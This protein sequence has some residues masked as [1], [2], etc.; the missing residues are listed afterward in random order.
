MTAVIEYNAVS[1][2]A[3]LDVTGV[4]GELELFGAV[5]SENV[6]LAAVVTSGDVLVLNLLPNEVSLV[7]KSG[8]VPAPVV[9]LVAAVRVISSVVES[10]DDNISDVAVVTVASD[11]VAPDVS[12]AA[13]LVASRSV[14]SG[15]TSVTSVECIRVAF[16][17]VEPSIEPSVNI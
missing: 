17:V 3:S 5:P 4:S 11:D 8:P 2:L 12:A 16:A 9:T 6:A 1:F 10:S 13:A 7:D 15:V 14:T